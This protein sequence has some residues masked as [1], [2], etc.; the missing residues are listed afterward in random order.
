MRYSID[1]SQPQ[2]I[3]P[4]G[5]AGDSVVY[6]EGP[7]TVYLG[8]SPGFATDPTA[9]GLPL[10][11]Y[12]FRDWRQ[13]VPLWAQCSSGETATVNVTIAQGGLIA[14]PVGQQLVTLANVIAAPDG[15]GVFDNRTFGPFNMKRFPGYRLHL[16]QDVPALTPVSTAIRGV[17]VAWHTNPTL[18]TVPVD[19]QLDPSVIDVEY[20]ATFRDNG[21][22]R[23]SGRVR[24]PYMTVIT[25]N[26]GATYNRGTFRLEGSLIPLGA[27]TF[28]YSLDPNS[29]RYA[30]VNGTMNTNGS[31]RVVRC[32]AIGIAAG[33]T[34]EFYPTTWA[35]PATVTVR[36]I[37]A[38]ATTPATVIL[39]SLSFNPETGE[40]AFRETLT[41]YVPVSTTTLQSATY[42]TN[43]WTTN[44]RVL[45]R[46]SSSA[47]V[48]IYCTIAMD[49]RYT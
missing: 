39:G 8:A 31:N 40:E 33:T 28:K 5:V 7:S 32:E 38:V 49:G 29:T 43:L 18:D 44:T 15:D 41:Y 24:A 13:G 20:H 48:T 4:A 45:I 30:P 34:A 27:D 26:L 19:W 10:E 47:S 23:L 12:T 1:S 35:G 11:A 42:Q 2:G 16:Y 9:N 17:S 37:T 22:M 36:A 14:T 3:A 21:I 6:N 25:N 46:N